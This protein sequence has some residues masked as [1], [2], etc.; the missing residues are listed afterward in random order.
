[1]ASIFS[2]SDPGIPTRT[3]PMAILSAVLKVR[4]SRDSF[5]LCL[6]GQS[7]LLSVIAVFHSFLT[8]FPNNLS[9]QTFAHLCIQTALVKFSGV[10]HIAKPVLGDFIFLDLSLASDTGLSSAV[11]K[12]YLLGSWGPPSFPSTSPAAASKF[13]LLISPG[14]PDL[15]TLEGS[16]PSFWTSFSF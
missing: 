1:M 13:P 10:L 15:W 3:V 4:G 7:I 5:W 11:Q 9:N 2:L 16:R 6:P 12:R 8:C 14:I